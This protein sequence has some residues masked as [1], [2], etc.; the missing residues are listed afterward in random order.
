MAAATP[1]RA[2]ALFGAPHRAAPLGAGGAATSTPRASRY[3]TPLMGKS[4]LGKVSEQPRQGGGMLEHSVTASVPSRRD[5]TTRAAAHQS[6]R[7]RQQRGATLCGRAPARGRG[8]ARTSAAP[9][10]EPQVNTP[11][12]SCVSLL[13]VWSAEDARWEAAACCGRRGDACNGHFGGES[14]SDVVASD[15]HAY[16]RVLSCIIYLM[17]IKRERRFHRP[18]T[19][20]LEYALGLPRRK[21]GTFGRSSGLGSE[22]APA[23]RSSAS[24]TPLRGAICGSGVLRAAVVCAAARPACRCK[25]CVIST[26]TSR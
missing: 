23:R 5:E 15:L 19:Q 20:A 22:A 17:A 12:L 6:A 2:A 3:S 14:G 7:G 18:D 11:M 8:N 25:V 21:Q 24:A 13:K 4:P 26:N 16:F 10:C 1:S 9:R